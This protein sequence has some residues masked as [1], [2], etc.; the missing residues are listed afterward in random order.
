MH[1]NAQC[2]QITDFF[3]LE[4]A[5]SIDNSNSWLEFTNLGLDGNGARVEINDCQ[6]VMITNVYTSAGPNTLPQ[7]SQAGS[8][9]SFI[10]THFGG[11]WIS[12]TSGS[13]TLIN[14]SPGAQQT[15][16]PLIRQTGGVLRL[17]DSYLIAPSGLGAWTT[18]PLVNSTSGILILENNIFS[19]MPGGSTQPGI[20]VATDN[21]SNVVQGNLL[22]G[23]TWT[24]P[25]TLGY[26]GLNSDGNSNQ[27]VRFA[28]V[29]AKAPTGAS[30]GMAMVADSGQQRALL[31]NTG[32]EFN[33]AS[34]R[35]Q[36]I[37]G[38]NVAESGW[39]RR[40]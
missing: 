30:T 24:L 37:F 2:V 17:V 7:I 40:V 9:T 10:N 5:I 36:W 12:L 28:R 31:I 25:G 15:T 8:G 29:E 11:G 3:T 13:M 39:Q 20:Y 26:Y 23:W 1:G 32:N 19:P 33:P 6:F 14:I 21:A 22:N 4:A 27:S 34:L 16:T 38:T 18:V 35:W